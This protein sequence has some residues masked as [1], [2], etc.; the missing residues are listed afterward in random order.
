MKV[1]AGVDVSR[2][3]S[4]MLYRLAVGGACNYIGFQTSLE[5]LSLKRKAVLLAIITEVIQYCIHVGCTMKFYGITLSF[6]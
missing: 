1:C 6:V 4:Y 3:W 2:K 5:G